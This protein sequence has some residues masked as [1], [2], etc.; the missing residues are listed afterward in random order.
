MEF[1]TIESTWMPLTPRQ[2]GVYDLWPPKCNQVI[3]RG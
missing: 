3:N 1:D 2:P